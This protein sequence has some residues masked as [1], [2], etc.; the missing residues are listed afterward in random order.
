MA[1]TIAKKSLID[2]EE[3]CHIVILSILE[4]DQS[5]IEELIKKKQLRYWLAR[6]MMNQYNSTT[7][8]YHYTYRK[9]AERH[10]EAKQ[11]ILLWFD[12]DIEKKI[13]DEEKIDFI[14]STLSDMPYFDKTVT[15][16]YYEHGHS[17][18][19]MSEDTGISKTTL[20]KALKRTKNEIKEK[21]KQRTWR[22][23]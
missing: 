7:S 1:C 10:R 14:N 3:L 12:S 9:P 19:T 11:D 5:K 15:E 23:D 6:M 17:F 2:C 13:K 20:F 22:H 4:S 18:K 8:P 16:I 21:A